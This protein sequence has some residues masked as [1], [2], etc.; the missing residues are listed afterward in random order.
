MRLEKYYMREQLE[1]DP[2][3]HPQVLGIDEVSIRK[4]HIYRTVVSGRRLGDIEERVA[5]IP[6]K[7]ERRGTTRHSAHAAISHPTDAHVE[8]RRV[9]AA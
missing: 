9:D 3:A 4:G 2:R 8:N 1:R 5:L 7:F 6:P